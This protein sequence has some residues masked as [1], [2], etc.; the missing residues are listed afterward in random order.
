M[1]EKDKML[2]IHGL[3][4]GCASWYEIDRLIEQAE[5]DTAVEHLRRIQSRK[6]HQEEYKARCL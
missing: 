4:L 2:I 1:S 5:S 3:L 6:Y